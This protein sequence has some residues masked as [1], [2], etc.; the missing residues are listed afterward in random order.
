MQ[1]S[2][3]SVPVSG[4]GRER[5]TALP[6]RFYKEVAI[7]DERDG[8]ATLLLDGRPVRTPG[9]AP[10]VLPT[11]ELAEAVAEQWRAQGERID[12]ET[13]PLTRLANSAIDDVRGREDA[14]ID[15]ILAHAGSDLLCYRAEGPKGLVAEQSKHWEQRRC[16]LPFAPSSGATP[17]TSGVAPPS[18]TRGRGAG[19]CGSATISPSPPVGEGFPSRSC[20][21]GMLQV[22]WRKG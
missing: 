12:P 6:K 17:D 5:K 20:A 13:M 21:R 22:A 16:S 3:K 7:E 8:G 14:V 10:L 11:R 15:D 18:P 9:K 4:N 19:S 1:G 2:D